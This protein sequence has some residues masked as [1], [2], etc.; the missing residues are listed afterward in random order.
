[1]PNNQTQRITHG[2]MIIALF[3]IF[4]AIAYYVPIIG[5]ITLFFAPLPIVWFSTKYERNISIL[6]GIIAC[7]V[8][9]FFGGIMI[10]PFSIIFAACGVVMG[11]ALRLGKS[12]TY[13]Y[14]STSITVLLTFAL[15]YVATLKLFE[16]DFIKDSFQ[17]LRSS[18]EESFKLAEQITGQTPIPQEAFDYVFQTMEMAIPATITLGVFLFAFVLISINLPLLKRFDIAVPRFNKFKELRLPRT[19]LWIYFIILII[20]LFVRPE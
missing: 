11:N 14:F 10:L 18:Y 13:L 1:M 16:V 3:A 4:I 17:M 12:K 20:N 2:A 9:F 15:Y 8:T 7:I 19:V 6:V 5:F